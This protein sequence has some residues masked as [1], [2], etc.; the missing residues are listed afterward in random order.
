MSATV[1]KAAAT[2]RGL[3]DM[4][5]ASGGRGV[6]EKLKFLGRLLEFYRINQL[7]MRTKGVGVMISKHLADVIYGGPLLK[8][9]SRLI[10]SLSDGGAQS[11]VALGRRIRLQRRI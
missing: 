9:P 8:S 10:Q 1:L 4:M 11:I 7:Q 5:S 3:L 6:P 2:V